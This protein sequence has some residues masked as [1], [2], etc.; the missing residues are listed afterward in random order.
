MKIKSKFN[1]I[2]L[3]FFCTY[4]QKLKLVLFSVWY[5]CNLSR[6]DQMK[7]KFEKKSLLNI[8]Y[9]IIIV[10]CKNL[11]HSFFPNDDDDNGFNIKPNNNNNHHLGPFFLWKKNLYLFLHS[12]TKSIIILYIILHNNISKPIQ[13]RQR[14]KSFF[15]LQISHR[16]FFFF[17]FLDDDEHNDVI[18]WSTTMMMILSSTSSSDDDGI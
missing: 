6:F 3:F 5:S 16:R 15:F 11:L 4:N 8:H 7:F 1:L 17:F 12:F 18:V 2:S 13:F 10:K 14:K 9:I